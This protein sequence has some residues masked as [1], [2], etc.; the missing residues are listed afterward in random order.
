MNW[1][2]NRREELHNAQPEL[3]QLADGDGSKA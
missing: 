2:K 3:K 1:E